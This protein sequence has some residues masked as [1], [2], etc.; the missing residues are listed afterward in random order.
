M[1]PRS[2]AVVGASQ[3]ASRG[4][5]VLLNLIETGFTGAVFAVN[6]RYDEVHGFPCVPSVGA[7]PE[8]IDCVVAAIPAAGV[9]DV[10]AEAWASG[11]RAAVVLSSGFGE[12]G[13]GLDRVGRLRELAAKGM[14]ICGPNCYGVY[15]VATGAAA[16]SGPTQ[17]SVAGPVAVVSQSGGFS[18]LISTPL[19]EDRGIGCSH[20]ISCGNQ[21]GVAVE[22]YLGYLVERPETTVIAAFVEGFRRPERL[23]EVAAR[24]RETGTSIVVLKS[25]RSEAGQKAVMSHTGSLAGSPEILGA[26]LARHGVVQVNTID[27]LVETTA[28]L[29]TAGPRRSVSRDVVVITGSGGESSHVADAADQ[30]GISMPKLDDKTV[31]RI[32]DL[33]PDF[34]V[35]G[36]PVDGTGAMFENPELF[37][38]LLDAVLDDP[39]D[40]VVA[41]NLGGR[42]PRGPHAPMRRFAEAVASAAGESDKLIVGY[43][44][45]T[46][47]PPDREMIEG[48]YRAGV[49]YVSS[50]EAA[51]RVLTTVRRATEHAAVGAGERQATRSEVD[52]PG[53]VL[54]F[55]TARDLLESFGIPVVDTRRAVSVDDAVAAADSV[56]YP[57]VVKAEAPGLQHK[58]DVGGVVVGCRDAAAVRAA[59]DQVT[60]SVSEAGYPVTEVHVQPMPETAAETVIGVAVDPLLGPAVLFGLGGVFVEII[61]D[62]VV[63][64]PPFTHEQAVDLIGRIRSAALLRGARGREPADVDALADMIVRLG[65]LAV[66]LGD[67]LLSLDLNPVLVGPAGSGAI[68]VDALVELRGD[69]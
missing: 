11:T 32:E 45:S 54:P 33:L 21:I 29:A 60:R 38:A 34:G 57:V 66:V 65:D 7:L 36:N 68:A 17:G 6:P 53:G 12:G 16:F 19:M 69:E 40:F 49:P 64:I 35:A 1:K 31:R 37:P 9:P 18:T 2:I 51:V 63:D 4:S 46:L 20:I 24:A 59:Y 48:L 8:P 56:G 22:D 47:G 41:V 50:T 55:L 44:T 67:R 61:K 5:R 14:A 43:G 27:E 39:Q 23:G 58:S 28:F 3:R 25:G 26:L 15:N 10:L 62:T 13:G 30:A 42:A 52:V